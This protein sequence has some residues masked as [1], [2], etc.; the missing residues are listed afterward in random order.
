MSM[1]TVDMVV[2]KTVGPGNEGSGI[3]S[4]GENTHKVSGVWVGLLL[5]IMSSLLSLNLLGLCLFLTEIEDIT[6]TQ[7]N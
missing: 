1:P 2:E 5:E 3:R 7:L 4:Y 6:R